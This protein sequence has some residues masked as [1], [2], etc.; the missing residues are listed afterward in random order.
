MT[1][2]TKQIITNGVIEIITSDNYDLKHY[3]F[4]NSIDELDGPEDGSKPEPGCKYYKAGDE[5]TITIVLKR[6]P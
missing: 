5:L 2:E 6:K 1:E 4:N 3:N